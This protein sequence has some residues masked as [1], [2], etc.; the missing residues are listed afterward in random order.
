MIRTSF[1]YKQMH[2]IILRFGEF[3]LEFDFTGISKDKAMT[4][5]EKDKTIFLLRI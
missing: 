1:K 3:Q 4:R 2:I 5:M